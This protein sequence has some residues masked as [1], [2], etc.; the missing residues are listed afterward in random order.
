[1]HKP[2]NTSEIIIIGAGLAGLFAA[3]KLAPQSVT[4]ISPKPLGK[5]AASS[6][7]QGGIAAAMGQGDTPAS[8]A[9]DTIAA[10]AG[11]VDPKIA[12]SIAREAP[13]RIEDLLKFGVPFDRNLE[14]A[15]KLS[16]EAAHSINRIVRVKGD[17]AGRAIM[18]ALIN[19]V[20]AEP[21]IQIIENHE[22]KKYNYRRRSVSLASSWQT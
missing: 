21:S 7:A 18:N 12:L 20:R 4:I 8:H 1:M 22:A 19:A 11:L 17:M 13:E 9:K 10:G 14:G 6:W 2:L 3:L 15:L 5:G 16:R